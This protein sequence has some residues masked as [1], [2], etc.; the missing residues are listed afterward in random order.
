MSIFD[1][2]TNILRSVQ[3]VLL[4]TSLNYVNEGSPILHEVLSYMHDRY[5]VTF[6][7]QEMHRMPFDRALCQIDVLFFEKIRKFVL[8]KGSDC[9]AHIEISHK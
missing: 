9:K 2:A 8:T 4:E 6:D 1:G 7:I 5:F 3:A